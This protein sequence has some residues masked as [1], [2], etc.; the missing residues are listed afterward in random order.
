MTNP[1][2]R[3]P[4]PAPVHEYRLSVHSLPGWHAELRDL[5]APDGAAPL[6]FDT[7]LEL[8]RHLARHDGVRPGLR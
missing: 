7:P 8:A 1:A 3:D 4:K 6:H 2:C 5:A